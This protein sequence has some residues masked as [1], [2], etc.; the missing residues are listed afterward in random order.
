MPD[1]HHRG[2]RRHGSTIVDQ[3][4]QIRDLA[5]IPH[6]SHLLHHEA[7][8]TGRDRSPLRRGDE[9]FA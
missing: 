5:I 9:R 7:P 1:D 6:A 8:D 3:Y 2:R 4:Q